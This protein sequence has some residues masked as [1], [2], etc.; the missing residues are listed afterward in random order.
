MPVATKALTF[1]DCSKNGGTAAL[2]PDAGKIQGVLR[3]SLPATCLVIEKLAMNQAFVANYCL[4]E[5]GEKHHFAAL[6]RDLIRSAS[7]D[8]AG[9]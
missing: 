2:F 4:P 6:S 9:L 1:K 3:D 7:A 8:V 5:L